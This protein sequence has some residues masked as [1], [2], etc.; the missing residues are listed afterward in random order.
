MLLTGG[1]TFCAAISQKSLCDFAEKPLR[2]IDKTA[3]NEYNRTI[4]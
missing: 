2:V 3:G 1:V 4:K